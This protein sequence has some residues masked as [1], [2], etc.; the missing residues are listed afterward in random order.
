[1]SE[2]FSKRDKK[3][4]FGAVSAKIKNTD[5]HRK[6]NGVDGWGGGKCVFRIVEV[7]MTIAEEMRK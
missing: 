3:V 4:I 2:T 1:M 5:L 7:C 6:H